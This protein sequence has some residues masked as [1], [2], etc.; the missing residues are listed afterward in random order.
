MA[1]RKA[2]IVKDEIY[3]VFNR[4]I[5]KQ[6]IFT[7]SKDY[8]RALEVLKFYLYGKP[9]IRF[10]Y[11]NKLPINQKSEFLANLTDTKPVVELICFCLMPNHV[12]FLLKNLTDNGVNK[13]MSNFQNSYARYFNT[14]ENRSGSLF[15]QNFK[16]VRIESDEQLIHVS[17]YIHLNPVTSF[18][19]EANEL[20][21]YLWS[22]YPDYLSGDSRNVSPHLVLG[23]F[24]RVKDYEKFVLDQ[25]DYQ[26]KLNQIKH[27]AFE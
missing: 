24:R 11:Y 4:S 3:H 16:A 14:K 9:T 13:F 25:V 5:A 19:I 10:S 2:P 22:S 8:Q 17:R 26:R 1:Y 7:R 12:H 15:Q 21:D 6:P 18:I 23:H 27:L 20:K